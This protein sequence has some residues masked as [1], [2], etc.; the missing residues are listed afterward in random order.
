[1][2]DISG[3]DLME[4]ILSDEESRPGLDIPPPSHSLPRQIG[5]YARSEINPIVNGRDRDGSASV[6]V[7]LSV[8]STNLS[9]APS[10][11]SGGKETQIG[12]LFTGL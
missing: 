10:D 7:T 11:A 5:G 4:V 12:N 1:M 8:P 6:G 3:E 2:K 9:D